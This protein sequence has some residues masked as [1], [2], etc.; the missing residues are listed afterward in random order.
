MK[1]LKE[2]YDLLGLKGVDKKVQHLFSKVLQED[3]FG[4]LYVTFFDGQDAIVDREVLSVSRLKLS[5][6]GVAEFSTI[7]PPLVRSLFISDSFT[8]LI[9]FINGY[10]NNFNLEY[11]AFMATGSGLDKNLFLKTIQK[12]SAIK[13]SY[14]IYGNSLLGKIKDCKV[15]HWINGRD[16]LFRLEGDAIISTYQNEEFIMDARKFTVRDH[17]RQLSMRQT[18]STK[19]PKN[20]KVENFYESLGS[21]SY[22]SQIV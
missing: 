6:G 21:L 14:S 10:Y 22:I 4:R 11:A 19:K 8:N 20:K 16:C 17:L 2:S 18:L 5:S 1:A 12:Y 13:K 9:F 15:Q 7:K 3:E